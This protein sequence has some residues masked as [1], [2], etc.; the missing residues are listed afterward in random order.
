ML[1]SQKSCGDISHEALQE[2]EPVNDQQRAD[3]ERF[4]HQVEDMYNI[5]LNISS[6]LLNIKTMMKTNHKLAI[7]TQQ[8]HFDHKNEGM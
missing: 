7:G 1:S 5:L 4:E 3:L 2:D 6:E 8:Q